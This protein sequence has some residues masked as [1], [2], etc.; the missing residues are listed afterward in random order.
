MR[1]SAKGEYGVMAI[2][3]LAL[4]SGQGP[5]Q[6]RNIAKKQGIPVRFLEQVM[7]AL[8][9]AG[10]VESIR[11][12]QGGYILARSSSEISL[13]Q[14]LEAIDGPIRPMDCVS[15][16]Q[17]SLC[18]QAKDCI[19]KDVWEE[20]KVSIAGVLNSITLNDMCERKRKKGIPPHIS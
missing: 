10:L 12:A 15:N 11:G 19:V 20:V 8:K 3:E 18:R 13:A 4:N 16:G 14:V 9:K 5:V 7:S 2:L 1:F 17:T 6:V